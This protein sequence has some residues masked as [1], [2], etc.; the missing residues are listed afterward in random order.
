MSV[1][2]CRFVQR[3]VVAAL[4]LLLPLAGHAQVIGEVM[5]ADG[6]D[7]DPS[8]Q[9]DLESL[10]GAHTEALQGLFGSGG[11]AVALTITY[12]GKGRRS[13]GDAYEAPVTGTSSTP[14]PGI[15]GVSA[16]NP[17]TGNEFRI[18]I[19]GNDLVDIEAETARV[20]RQNP[21]GP[22]GS[23]S[24]TDDPDSPVP[25]R[26][27]PKAWSNNSDNRVLRSSLTEGTTS[28]PWR[29]IA[30]HSNRCTGTLV[31]PR[32]VVTAGHCLY[33]RTSNT[34][35]SAFFVTPGRAGNNWSYGRSRVPT[36]GQFTWYFTP[37]QWRQANPGGGAG[38]YDLGIIVLPD[39]LGDQTGWMGYA[40]L[41]NSDLQNALVFNRGFP[42]CNAVDQNGN[43]RTDDVGDDPNS[44]LTCVDRHL[45]GDANSCSIGN[46]HDVDGDQWARRFDHS[47][48]ASAAQ[49]GSPLYTYL[50]GVPAVIGVHTTSLCNKT[51][52]DV[53]CLPTDQRPLRATRFT[54]EYR[55]WISY[56]RNWK[57]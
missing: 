15:G 4:V 56:F 30:E 45:W 39:R 48:D 17:D 29:A 40:T 47:C 43:A 34:W 52:A 7:E 20:G 42:W 57:P 49:S 24:P 41:G 3:S 1:P 53:P 51:A 22:N 6:F 12:V 5:Y 33:N 11:P 37:W 23:P 46:F 2:S 32:H 35:S 16:F 36:P 28:W 31:G 10:Q 27:A 25:G 44:G 38:Q 26:A 54:P 21:A 9:A 8:I 55:A 19:A 14:S 50:N 13:E 18:Q